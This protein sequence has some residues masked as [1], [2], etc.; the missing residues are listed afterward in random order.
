[1]TASSSSVYITTLHDLNAR[2]FARHTCACGDS[3]AVLPT[4]AA[5][6]PARWD[7]GS[8][9]AAADTGSD[10]VRSTL[11]SSCEAYQ[12]HAHSALIH[13]ACDMVVCMAV[14]GAAG[15]NRRVLLAMTSADMTV[16]PEGPCRCA[17]VE[18][19]VQGGAK[20]GGEGRAVPGR[21]EG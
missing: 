13:S 20:V 5:A 14:L 3:A 8:E 11:S 15:R 21:R 12:L 18:R 7:P 9:A 6:M 16:H 19:R 1:M 2:L 10:A 17:A 4:A